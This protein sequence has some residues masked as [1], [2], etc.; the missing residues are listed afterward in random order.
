VITTTV[1]LYDCSSQTTTVEV[2]I[3]YDIDYCNAA[4]I[5]S[6]YSLY[7][8]DIYSYSTSTTSYD[9]TTSEYTTT[10]T[11]YYYN[12]DSQ[13]YY[14]SSIVDTYSSTGD[15]CEDIPSGYTYSSVTGLY[16]YTTTSSSYD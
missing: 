12:C 11:T 16:T 13:T 14:S 6:G 7:D 9:D 2:T 10:T 4:Q 15:D 8:G 5:P 1:Y 3:S